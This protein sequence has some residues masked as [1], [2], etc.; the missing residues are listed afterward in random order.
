MKHN[1]A[2]S[3]DSFDFDR[4]KPLLNAAL[5][6]DLDDALIWEQ[7]YNAITESTPPPRPIAS[8]LQQTPWLCNTSSFADSS[9]H[10]KYVDVVLKEEL[11]PMYVGL[12]NVHETYFEDVPGLET[13]SEA[14]FKKCMEAIRFLVKGGADGRK[15][16]IKMTF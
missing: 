7:V 3:S 8:S 4:I 6:D 2:V 16:Q 9:E 11:G 13:A 12:R 14:V 10:H 5:A 1:S 15:M